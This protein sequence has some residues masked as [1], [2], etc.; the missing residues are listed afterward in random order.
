MPSENK[1]FCP[2]CKRSF[3]EQQICPVCK[4]E[5]IN[6][7]KRWRFPKHTASKQICKKEL[8][9][10]TWNIYDENLKNLYF[11]HNIPYLI[12]DYARIEEKRKIPK[13]EKIY[14]LIYTETK[15]IN[16][17]QITDNA[18]FYKFNRFICIVKNKK[19]LQNF[20]KNNYYKL[21]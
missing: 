7:G 13:E 1:Y 2:K 3:K 14:K 20:L 17:N 21:V 12:A 15:K 10:L 9:K 18:S 16:F 11:L 19:I 4:I 5:M 6:M 8:S